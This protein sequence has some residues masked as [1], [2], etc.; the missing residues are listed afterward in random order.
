MQRIVSGILLGSLVVLLVLYAPLWLFAFVTCV[1]SWLALYEFFR[2]S[3]KAGLPC[4][5]LLGY[6]AAA[7]VTLRPV[8]QI[9]LNHLIIVFL[10]F[11]LS[12][13]LVKVKDQSLTIKSTSATFMG[14]FYTGYF[15]SLLIPIRQTLGAR[16]I[17]F[18]FIV[19]WIG[20]TA[21]Y[22]VGKNLGRHRLAP[23]ISPK[24]TIEGSIGGLAGSV[25]GAYVFHRFWPLR[26]SLPTVILIAAVLN[27]FAQMGDLAESGLKRGAQVKD[28]SALIPGHGG[29]LD[30]IDSLLFSA[31]IL[32]LFL[33]I[34]SR[35][36][37][38]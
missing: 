7:M 26:E 17:L 4:F 20:D 3:E 38:P 33:A 22:Y 25:L 13:A 12:F 36:S 29:M 9:D 32:Y 1:V 18:L 8:L 10:L 23:R 28:S 5:Q 6:A 35:H 14:V 34:L 2:L 31:P 24:K 19:T 11:L 15:L 16:Y 21:A 27:L 37:G 30:R